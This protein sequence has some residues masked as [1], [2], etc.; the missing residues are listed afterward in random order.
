MQNEVYN[1]GIY[2]QM[3]SVRMGLSGQGNPGRW[4]RIQEREDEYFISR[5]KKGRI[6]FF[7][8]TTS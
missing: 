5:S 7:L 3:F 8:N 6:Y 1:L 2:E 4:A